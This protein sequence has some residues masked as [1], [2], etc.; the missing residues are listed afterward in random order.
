MLSPR[1]FVLLSVAGM[2]A[3]G[4]AHA[5]SDQASVPA[6]HQTTPA[7]TSK[8][9][10]TDISQLSVETAAQTPAAMSALNNLVQQTKAMGFM[11][12]SQCFTMRSYKFKGDGIARDELRPSGETTCEAAS[13]FTLKD[14]AGSK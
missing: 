5:S 3:A 12:P 14:A 10:T 7:G 11:A 13:L 2:F 9:A 8:P 4:L 6:M 1:P